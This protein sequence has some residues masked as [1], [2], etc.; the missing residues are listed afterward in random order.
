MVNGIKI[1]KKYAGHIGDYFIYDYYGN[2][3]R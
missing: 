2:Q 1:K 3:I